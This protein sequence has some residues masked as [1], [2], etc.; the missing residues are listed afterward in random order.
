[1]TARQ[2]PPRL[3]PGMTLGV[4]APSSPVLERSTVNRGVARLEQLGFTVIFADHAHDS[5]GYLAG[6]DADRADDL[7]AMLERDD[8]DGVICLRGGNGAGRTLNALNT[9]ANRARLRRLAGRAPKP[10]I[11]YSDITMIHALL[12]RE[13]GWVSFYGPVVTSFAKMTEYTV[14]AFRR[15]LLEVAPFDIL[16]DPDDPYAAYV[17]DDTEDSDTED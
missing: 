8:I 4:V 3:R 14:A 13:L 11:G 16:P 7:L 6:Q 15:A 10:F 1:M 5:R 12:A 2:I 17:D 9:A